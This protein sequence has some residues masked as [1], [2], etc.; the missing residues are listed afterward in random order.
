MP[1]RRYDYEKKF[2][3]TKDYSKT[4]G[5]PTHVLAKNMQLIMDWARSGISETEFKDRVLDLMEPLVGSGMSI[6]KFKKFQMQ[7]EDSAYPYHKTRTGQDGTFKGHES[8]GING[9]LRFLI[10]FQLAGS[11]LGVM[12]DIEDIDEFVN[13]LEGSQSMGKLDFKDSGEMK[14]HGHPFGKKLTNSSTDTPIIKGTG[15]G[16]D[17]K[18]KFKHNLRK[19]NEHYSE[20]ANRKYDRYSI[21]VRESSGNI[22]RTKARKFMSEAILDLEEVLQLHHHL[23]VVLECHSNGRVKRLASIPVFR[24]PPLMSEDQPIFRFKRTAEK[25]ARHLVNEGKI[26]RIYNHNWGCCVKYLIK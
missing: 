16:M 25:A 10:N 5:N 26:C 9:M 15:K 1:E 18:K 17:G 23:D 3:S 6:D 22:N 2:T 19:L 21:L 12:E 13:L 7:L 4:P 20:H 14:D 24:R 11:G 8:S